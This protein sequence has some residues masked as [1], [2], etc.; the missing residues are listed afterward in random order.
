MT[1]ALLS[2]CSGKKTVSSY[3]ST[4]EIRVT[5]AVMDSGSE[6]SSSSTTLSRPGRTTRTTATYTASEKKESS[7]TST[8]AEK[9]ESS[10]K[11]TNSGYTA[12]PQANT[13]APASQNSKPSPT[14]NTPVSGDPAPKAASAPD[15]VDISR[16]SSALPGIS[17]TSDSKNIY[18]SGT[19]KGYQFS[20]TIDLSKW[21][22]N[23]SPDQIVTAS[24]LF[25]ECY[26]RM[27]ARFGTVS[28]APRDVILAIENEG[29]APAEASGEFVHIH[30][31]WLRDN[32]N[33][34]DCL[35]HEFAHVIQNG[36]D[37]D[38][39]G[40]SDFIERFAD[41]CRYEYAFRSGL[42]NDS[43]WTLW[44]ADYENS[45]DSSNRFYVW[46]DYTYST[47]SKDIMLDFFRVCYE[48]KYPSF[49]WD[50]AWQEI[51][52]GSALEGRSIDD[53][54]NEFA[55]SDF[56]YLSADTSYGSSE[57]L[58]RYDIRSRLA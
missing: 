9:K 6:E 39:C 2:S 16:F 26:P 19:V 12:I 58:S 15:G 8:S 27:Y 25:W 11:R 50:E 17:I 18:Q 52:S 37:G 22:G 45:I 24:Q 28:A 29:Y 4:Y 43:C 35:T 41:F 33:D 47:P 42:Y 13:P 31:S 32:P 23:T 55:A 10:D 36:W 38:F 34:F 56:A 7:E 20:L 14:V 48:E 5:S 44:S 49:Q 40:S 53:V 46:L 30:D 3:S 21:A 51:F 54:W 1:A 57:L